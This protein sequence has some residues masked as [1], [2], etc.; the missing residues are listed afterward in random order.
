MNQSNY[1]LTVDM[2]NF[3]DNGLFTAVHYPNPDGSDSIT[4]GS[5]AY[6]PVPEPATMLPLGTG[7]AGLAGARLRKKE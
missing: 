5:Y 6:P 2:F 4:V 1:D 7:L 3:A